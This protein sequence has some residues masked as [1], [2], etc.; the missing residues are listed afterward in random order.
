MRRLCLQCLAEPVLR[1]SDTAEERRRKQIWVPTMVALVPCAIALAAGIVADNNFLHAI[2][3]G[4]YICIAGNLVGLIVPFA[5][6]TVTLSLV[7]AVIFTLVAGLLVLDMGAAARMDSLRGWPW[8]VICMD[9]FLALNVPRTAQHIVLC[10][11]AL[12]VI[13]VH[14]EDGFRLG[15]YDIDGFSESPGDTAHACSCTNPPCGQGIEGMFRVAGVLGI[16]FIDFYATRDFAESMRTEQARVLAS[17][18]VAEQVA[19]SLARFDLE[20]AHEVLHSAEDSELPKSLLASLLRILHNLSSY[21][22]YLPQSCFCEP[23]DGTSGDSDTERASSL[24]SAIGVP[25]P[26]GCS[27]ASGSAGRRES[28]ADTILSDSFM[29]SAPSGS[30]VLSPGS[31]PMRVM[32]SPRMHVPQTRKAT[33][34]VRNICGF[35]SA[36]RPHQLLVPWMAAEVERFA[37]QVKAQGGVLDHLSGDHFSATF[38]AL[39]AQGSQCLAAVQAAVESTSTADRKV[40]SALQ[41]TAAICSG[42]AL[43]GDFGSATT[44]RFMVIGGVSAFITA[45]ERAAAAWRVPAVRGDVEQFWSCRLRKCVIFPK[46]SASRIGLWEVLVQ[47]LRGGES[48][49]WMYELANARADLWGVYSDAVTSW[50]D[51]RAEAALVTVQEALRPEGSPGGDASVRLGLQALRQQ[52]Q[53]GASPPVGEVTAKALAGH[54][55]PLVPRE[56]VPGEEPGTPMR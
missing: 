21:R 5:T 31:S 28:N 22:P 43:C 8:I 24:R 32:M 15:L 10:V 37:D 16:L 42:H 18:D 51:G 3:I 50:C 12:F 6:R 56:E 35:L 45:V 4:G 26:D 33:L 25:A 1:D 19:A 38:G 34:L 47:R 41:S 9:L 49:E 48:S 40:D 11:T 54:P 55:A 44:Q 52:L 39:K 29:V 2:P 30:I 27:A 20:A 23:T 53:L 36:A 17:V 46:L 14:I 7:I 13:V